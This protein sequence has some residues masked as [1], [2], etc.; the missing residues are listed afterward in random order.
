[1][2]GESN[3]RGEQAKN[4]GE[5][6]ECLIQ[7]WRKQWDS[8]LSFYYVQLANFTRGGK[9]HPDCVHVQDEMRRLIDDS[10]SKTGHVGMA[11]INDIGHPTDIHPKN[12]KDVGKRL[13]TLDWGDWELLR[14]SV[15]KDR[16]RKAFLE[17]I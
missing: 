13:A 15:S 16:G 10:N 2:T 3:A 6:L 7:D 8:N 5:L 9:D 11:T 12:K 1:M 4:Y 14:R 17:H